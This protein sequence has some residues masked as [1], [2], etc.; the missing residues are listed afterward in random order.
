MHYPYR[1][2]RIWPGI[3]LLLAALLV[4][5]PARAEMVELLPQYRAYDTPRAM[6]NLS[7]Q[8]AKGAWKKI[9]DYRGKWLLVNAWATW[10]APCR[11]EMPELDNLQ[12]AYGEANFQILPISIDSPQ[13]APRMFQ[14]YHEK[15]IRNLPLLHDPQ[16]N[17]MR[18]M[19][20]RGLPSS[21]LV[22]PN[23]QMVGEIV[24]YAPWDSDRAAN[25]IEYY[26]QAKQ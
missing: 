20:P 4:G 6:P 5:L 19:R 26:L 11:K 10:C 18:L 16:G 9:S 1:K 8:D 7:F 3:F 22:N 2:W 21:W 17:L 15:Q 14:F 12:S 23:G 13:T 25:L 24:G